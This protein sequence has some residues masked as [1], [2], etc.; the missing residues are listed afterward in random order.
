M[1]MLNKNITREFKMSIARYISVS[2]LLMLGVFV[3][4]GLNVTGPNMRATAQKSYTAEH[5]ADAKVTSTI[6]LNRGDRDAIKDLSGIKQVEFGHTTDGVIKNTQHAMRIQSN[7]ETLSKLT[8]TKGRKAQNDSEIVLNDKLKSKYKINDK[9]T[10]ASGKEEGSTGLTHATFKVVGFA[11]STEFLKKDKIGSTSLGS[12]N[13][14]GFAYVTKNAFSDSDPNVARLSF[15][16]AKGKAYSKAYEHHATML[17]DKLQ[18][19]LNKRNDVRVQDLRDD[20]NDQVQT[21]QNQIKSGN[22][23]IKKATTK[24][25]QA[26]KQLN[27][28]RS[29]VEK[30]NNAALMAQVKSKQKELDQQKQTLNNKQD[31]LDQAQDKITDANAAK[32]QLDDVS[33]TIQSRNDYNDGYNDYG[34]DSER[35]D[36]LGK[37]FPA[38]FFLIAI[39]VSFTTMRRMVEEKRIE[40]GTLRALGYT[41]GEVMREFLIYSITTALTGTILGSWLGLVTLP[42]I[43]FRAYTANFNFNHLLLAFHPEYIIAGLG[44]ALASTVL[45]SWLAA[46]TSLKE[47][48]AE[49]ML[50]KPPT[51][52]SR[53]LLE[54]VTPLWKRMSFSHKV[55]AR[56]LFRYK[57]RMLM[58]IIGVAG[59]T[60]LMITGFGIRDS[61][62]TIV[63][64]QFGQI[65]RYDLVAVY[66]PE[67]NE[68]A[69]KTAKATVTD[70]DEVKKQTAAHF[71]NVYATSK[72]SDSRQ[73]ISLMVPMK[74]RQLD[75]YIKL[76]NYQTGKRLS[77]TSNG[78][79]VSQKLAK[80]QNVGVGDYFTIKNSDGT[81]HRVKVAG[82][83]TM[84]AGH[85]VY[86]DE[87]YYKKVFDE[88]A[89]DNAYLVTLKKVTAKKV[90]DFSAKF[91]QKEAAVQTIQSQETKQSI[92]NILSNLNNLILVLVLSASLLS[93]VVLYTLTNIN[94]SE[95]VRELSTL[96]VLG[97]YPKE[98]L[99]YIYRE[100]NILTGVGILTGIGVG[101]L[102]H[103]YIMALLPPATAMVAPGLTWINI[104]ISVVLTTVFSLIVMV[105]MNRKIQKVDMLEALKS[106]D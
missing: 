82:I 62:N 83:T 94:V 85:Y 84:Y 32:K 60:A 68:E 76:R 47:I 70:S 7:P 39:L 65:S 55:T 16:T 51:G 97:F 22:D 69:L 95:R 75:Q 103:A 92:T 81:A 52:G 99:M 40:M 93:L 91:N 79:I 87:S 19:K 80:L 61:L 44:L 9:I 100:T 11:T 105:L 46:R 37:S 13:L 34:E 89:V 14:Y 28:R 29:Q 72:N 30:A 2:A 59:A 104:L 67:A 90:N 26:Q 98:V 42:K 66:N 27:Q 57:G 15:K 35:I 3:L 6:E 56:N 48:P 12:G 71:T 41:K 88:N 50:P 106:V 24:L 58:T 54:R 25:N 5:L 86:M 64:R 38:F 101:Y 43:I 36:A 63:D 45:A 4:I 53:I 20:L 31:D 33:L 18:K 17:V 49:L 102:F 96:K 1:K 21:A 23:E 73:N 10:I 77:L 74:K 78:A 8:I